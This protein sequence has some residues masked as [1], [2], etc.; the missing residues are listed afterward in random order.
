MFEYTGDVSGFGPTADDVVEA[1]EEDETVA[2]DDV[3][4]VDAIVVLLSLVGDD[5]T[6]K[7]SKY[8]I[9][10]HESYFHNRFGSLLRKS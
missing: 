5:G 1:E 8:N 4:T 9:N 3:E 2:V 10:F 6:C 7:W